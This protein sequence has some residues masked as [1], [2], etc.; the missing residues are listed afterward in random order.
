MVV[1]IRKIPNRYSTITTSK[2][3]QGFGNLGRA[4][5]YFGLR[6]FTKDF[7]GC[8]SMASSRYQNDTD[9]QEQIMV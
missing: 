2:K 4:K 3:G 8:F 9:N 7:K 1:M 5:S 6:I